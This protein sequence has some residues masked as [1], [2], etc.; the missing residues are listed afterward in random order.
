MEKGT[1][2]HHVQK[3]ILGFWSFLANLEIG[4]VLSRS[5][6]EISQSPKQCLDL[7]LEV[8]YIYFLSVAKIKQSRLK[9][10]Y[11]ESGLMHIIFTITV[12][13]CY[14]EPALLQGSV[15]KLHFRY[16]SSF[17]CGG[18]RCREEKK[19]NNLKL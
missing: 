12:V 2:A 1:S 15:Q 16:C 11:K 10:F 6:L 18:L 13:L 3:S 17:K 9:I 5:N 8:R 7:S 14:F 19:K 4:P